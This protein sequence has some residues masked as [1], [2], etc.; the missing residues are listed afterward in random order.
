VSRRLTLVV[1]V[2]NES[3]SLVG[4]LSN[5]EQMARRMRD[6][7]G[8]QLS[9]IAVDD[10]STDDSARYLKEYQPIELE[11]VSLLRLH[12]NSGSHVAIAMGLSQ[13][14]S[15]AALILAADGQDTYTA[16]EQMIESWLDGAEVVWGREFPGTIVGWIH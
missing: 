9:M 4:F 3:D 14:E 2:H 10:G 13:V 15:S 8:V 6:K 5:V 16:A 11:S 12:R 1:P 7:H